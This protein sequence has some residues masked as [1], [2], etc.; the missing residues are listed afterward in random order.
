VAAFEH[1]GATAHRVL[2]SVQD[3]MAENEK[4]EALKR[5]KANTRAAIKHEWHMKQRAVEVRNL[6]VKGSLRALAV[7]I[8][9]ADQYDDAVLA[10]RACERIEAALGEAGGSIPTISVAA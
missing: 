10:R 8:S 4:A 2:Y 9:L 3:A 6:A 7:F 1:I 5:A